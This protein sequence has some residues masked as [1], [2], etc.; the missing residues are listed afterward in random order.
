M[1]DAFAE[2]YAR[3]AADLHAYLVRLVGDPAAADELGQETFVRFLEHPPTAATQN[4]HLGPWLFRVAT[5]LGLDRLRRRRGRPLLEEPAGRAGEAGDAAEARDLERRIREEVAALAP[6]LRAAF[7]LR[8]H[9]AL[10]YAEIGRALGV[11]ER[12][13]KARFRRARDRLSGRLGPLLEGDRP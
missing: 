7:L 9:H 11:S 10:P 13:A 4:G 12:A 1:D 6:E 8:A 5:N 3:H 2:V